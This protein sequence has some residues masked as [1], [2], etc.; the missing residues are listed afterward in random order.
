LASSRITWKTH[1]LALGAYLL[2]ALA[3]TWP[4]ARHLGSH[5]PGNGVDDPP[6]TWNLWW[7]QH[8]LLSLRSNPFHSQ[9][10]F[11]PIGI[12][13][14]FYTLTMLNVVQSLPL[15]A[16]TGLL[17]ASNLILLSSFVLSG[18]GAFLLAR[19]LLRRDGAR[20][21]T[22]GPAL[23][24]GLAY[25][26][27]SSKLAY[28]ALGQWNI[29]SSQW[30]PFY[31]LFVIR[32]RDEPG[33]WRNVVLAGLC[34][35]FQA[36][37]EM[38]YAS[39]LLVWTALFA[40]AH[41]VR[42]QGG[43][44]LALL[45][46]LA[47][48]GLVFVA[49]FSPHLAAMLPDLRTEGDFFVEGQG[50]AGEFSADLVGFVVPTQYHPLLG[51][52]V[53]RF[54]F[55]HA[56]GQ[57]LYLGAVLLALAAVALLGAW[58]RPG[59]RFWAAS[60]VLF[61]LL[62]LGPTLR[63]NGSDT[64]VPLPF[65]LLARL[66]F[67]KGNRYPSRYSVL[68]VLSLAL[69]AAYGLAWLGSRRP[70]AS[71][72]R[73]R[74]V[75]LAL[76]GLFL[77]EHLSAPLPLTDL[78]VPPAYQAIAADPDVGTLLDLPVAWRNGFR[79]L[80]TQDPVIMFE[81]FCQTVHEKRLL[82][83]NTSRNPELAFQYFAEAPV[84]NSLIALETGKALP[85]AVVAADAALAPAVL[86]FLD[87]RWV[88]VRPAFGEGLV[89]YVEATMPLERTYAD[90][91]II[92]YRVRPLP[93]WQAFAA[94]PAEPLWRLVRAEGWGQPVQGVAWA[95]RREVRLLVPLPGRRL[96]LRAYAPGPG[97][98]LT[99]VVNG[100]P[101]P[102][103]ALG[104][105]WDE[106]VVEIPPGVARKGLNEVRLRFSRLWPA[107]AAGL[108]ARQIG[109]TGEV[110]PVHITV[111]SAGWDLGGFD[112]GHIYVDGIDVSPNARGYNL[113][114]IDA[115]TGEVA[116]VAHFDTH[117]ERD[118]SAALA[119]WVAGLPG[120]QIVAAAVADE[121]SL[122][123]SEEAVAALMRLGASGDLREGFRWGHA[124]VGVVDSPPGTAV[125]A[126]GWLR[127]ISLSVGD[128]LTGPQVAAALAE[129]R[130]EGASASAP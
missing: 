48:A 71:A 120:G 20:T 29:A 62:A 42:R 100:Q 128:G 12:N 15:Q 60:A 64:G 5:V 129:I 25:A 4:L 13:L 86:G 44:N 121:G 57:H 43:W 94:T 83:G 23:F 22:L 7:G 88:I 59:V 39:F 95:Q 93:A 74:G 10:L 91:E 26:F 118:A 8:G 32:L 124:L 52:L 99:P 102:H 28:A 77:F 41:L 31:V 3:L 73:R 54:A 53:E 33:R 114:V 85:E 58:R 79:V 47:L 84:I 110:S 117:G 11:Y 104:E 51:G 89:P 63:V 109:Q 80:G 81:Q 101:L 1:L 67:F 68:L 69:L 65:A 36:W 9:Y 38:T 103:I 21:P 50:F 119:A 105:G 66:P 35:A 72:G 27:A 70:F 82:A 17:V 40:A 78:R 49:A 112:L 61:W 46:R 122:R 56:V 106:Y 6:L 116:E 87:V 75:A 126:L 98:T 107:A 123:L 14:A 97:Q 19:T 96:V 76:G 24:A 2:L 45:G 16:V 90:D 111:Q 130:V 125:E 92:V 34:L 115:D 30:I 18:Y 55:P 113:A 108:G 37:A 127:P